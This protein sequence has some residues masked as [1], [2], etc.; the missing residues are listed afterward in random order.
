VE[1]QKQEVEYEDWEDAVEEISEKIV[2][3]TKETQNWQKDDSSGEEQT[4]NKE[5]SK[6]DAKVTNTKPIVKPQPVV[7]ASSAFDA[8]DGDESAIERR[9]R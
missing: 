3:K 1:E 4:I 7:A 6:K 8:K 5:E 2:Q 9:E